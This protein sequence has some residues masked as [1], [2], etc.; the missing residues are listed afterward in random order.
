[1]ASSSRAA[2]TAR[3]AESARAAETPANTA[4]SAPGRAAETAAGT[5][6]PASSRAA[7]SAFIPAPVTLTGDWVRLEPLSLE[8]HLD[9]LASIA[10]DPD[11]WRWTLNVV[12]TKDDLRRYLEEALREQAE[13]RSVPFAT[14]HLATGRPAGCTR[15]GNI[16]PRHRRVEIG[17]TWVG[18]EFQRSRVN[19]EAKLL[20][21]QH[22]FETWGC[23]RVELKT[24]VLNQRSR[25]AMLRLGA[26]EEGILRKHA[27]SDRG[28]PR[29]TVYYSVLDE[30]W[31][32]VKSRLQAMLADRREPK[33]GT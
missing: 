22:A 1:V 2:E 21:L 7:F 9:P 14:V 8:H 31:P 4:A 29:D 6:A 30:E 18:R 11:L 10:L 32:A 33:E 25:S 3:A 17:W 27:L 5:A 19:T 24:N 23:Q 12:E 15:F 13:G 16:E 20:M 26:K 28:V